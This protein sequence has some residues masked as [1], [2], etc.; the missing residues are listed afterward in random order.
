M[1]YD[2]KTLRNVSVQ[3]KKYFFDTNVWLL[4]LNE[5]ST[6]SSLQKQ[7]IDFFD[8]VCKSTLSPKP[9]IIIT[10]ILLSEIVNRYLRDVGFKIYCEENNLDKNNKDLY[11]S[12]YRK[13][14]Q[15]NI[16]YT[17][18]CGEIKDY[19][20]YCD[21]QN[22]SFGSDITLKV[23]LKNPNKGLDFNDTYYYH[24]CLKNSF[25]IVTNDSDFFVEKV[26][27]ITLNSTLYEKGKSAI[28]P[29]K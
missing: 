6:L 7:Y 4:K 3:P 16:D 23:L 21:L 19:H 13:S 22:D 14:E 28:V 9:K 20:N 26:E 2:I 12:N 24:L 25:S 18:I 1:A 17:F 11:K 15:F 10:A 27:V 8:N 5:P 29:K